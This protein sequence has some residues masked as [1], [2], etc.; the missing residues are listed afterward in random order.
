MVY[1]HYDDGDTAENPGELDDDGHGDDENI[2]MMMWA[3]MMM[4]MSM[5]MR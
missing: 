4:V 5:A 1:D 3:L 2:I